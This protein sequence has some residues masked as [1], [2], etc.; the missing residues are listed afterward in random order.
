[1]GSAIDDAVANV[2]IALANPA[3]LESSEEIAFRSPSGVLPIVVVA[4]VG[5]FLFMVLKPP[6]QPEPPK[7]VSLSNIELA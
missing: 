3:L 7:E 1:M 6:G 2:V 4:G 5:I